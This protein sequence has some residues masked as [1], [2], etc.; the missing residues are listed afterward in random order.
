MIGSLC[1]AAALLL[2]GSGVAKLRTPEPSLATVA[3][4]LRRRTSNRA[5]RFSLVRA[6][7][8]G[9]VIAGAGF[10]VFG[11]RVPAAAVA[12]LFAMFAAIA[13]ILLIRSDRVACGCFG[14]S[15]APIGISHLAVNVCCCAVAVACTIRP[16]G[17]LGGLLS[18]SGVVA[19]V[20]V[21]QVVLLAALGY[22]VMTA[23]P[24]LAAARR[25]G[26][27]R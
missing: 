24:A 3:A 18:A 23:L 27:A 12:L 10:L 11:G 9:E 15:D 8:A 14:R 2:L 5:L 1:A 4:L 22:L 21:V 16:V 20:G 19:I 13:V 25:L 26:A 6:V 7:A 17:P